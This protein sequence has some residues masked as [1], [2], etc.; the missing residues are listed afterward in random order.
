M[1]IEREL[2]ERWLDDTILEPEELD[3][4]MEETRELLAQPEQE[5]VA[6]MNESG[7]CFLSDGNKYSGLWTPL[8]TAPQKREPLSVRNKM[9]KE[10]ELLVKAWNLL[11]YLMGGKIGEGVSSINR[12]FLCAL[13]A[14]ISQPEQPE[15]TEQEDIRDV[16]QDG[17][18]AGLRLAKREPLSD[19]SIC[20][21]LLKKEWF[22]FVELVRQIEKA[23]GIGGGK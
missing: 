9:S 8:Y 2:L 10:K 11:I 20:E 15:Q 14:Y 3:S 7:G 12:K 5:P 4:L 22:G 21:I 17:Y 6:W 18:E 23:H 16:W 1:N 19:E 13:K